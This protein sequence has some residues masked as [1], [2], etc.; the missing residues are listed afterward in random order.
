MFVPDDL[1]HNAGTVFA[2]MKKFVPLAQID[3]GPADYIHYWTDSL[4]SQY[5]SNTLYFT[6]PR[7]TKIYFEAGHGTGPCEGI[8]GSAKRMADLVVRQNAE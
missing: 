8:G 1:G 5:R 4:T 2:F 7:T 6:L 3:L